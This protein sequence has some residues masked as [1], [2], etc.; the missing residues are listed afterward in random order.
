MKRINIV[1]KT[2]YSTEEFTELQAA[3]EQEGGR[4][5]ETTALRSGAGISCHIEFP[6]EDE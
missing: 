3:V 5:R 2:V 6:V 4:I 1:T